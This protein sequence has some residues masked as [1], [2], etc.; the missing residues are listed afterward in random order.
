MSVTEAP[1][2]S[3]NILPR[4]DDKSASAGVGFREGNL[5]PHSEWYPV[6]LPTRAQS[7]GVPTAKSGKSDGMTELEWTIGVLEELLL[8]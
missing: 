7:R 1:I 8:E 4:E 5:W 6:R 3:D 2:G